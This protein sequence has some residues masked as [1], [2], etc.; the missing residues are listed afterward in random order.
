MS[1]NPPD[2]KTGKIESFNGDVAKV[3]FGAGANDFQYFV[4]QDLKKV[5]TPPKETFRVGDVVVNEGGREGTI[6]AINGNS[7]KVRYG[8]GK[9]NFQME[10]LASLR[11][12]KTAASEAEQEKQRKIFRVEAEKYAPIVRLF[13]Q[14]YNPEFAKVKGGIDAAAIKKA[15]VE[16]AELDALCKSK[17]PGITNSPDVNYRDDVNWRF[18]DWCGMAAKRDELLQSVTSGT[19]SAV[20]QRFIA[21]WKRS[22]DKSLKDP[23]DFVWDDVQ[24][25][26]FDQAAWK[27]KDLPFLQRDYAENG[28]TVP[29]D[30]FDS[31]NAELA[32]LREKIE[33]DSK[34][35]VWEVPPYKDAAV[36]A[37][38]KSKHAARFKGIINVKS[39]LDFTT[40]K[41]F[42]NNLGIPTS[43]I[44][45][46][47]LLVKLPNQNGMCQAR[48]F[49]VE[50]EYTGG[51]TFSAMKIAGFSQA[52]KYMK[53]Q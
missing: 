1:C 33:N 41:L 39:G 9:Y 4:V 52:G 22:I 47:W 46:G 13:E 16:L 36:E 18:A 23:N 14:F 19:Q 7:A 29:A 35:K 30:I 27:A 26:L 43:Q 5:Q 2:G 12:P 28:G 40:W 38:V 3:R 53:C 50:K 20:G 49:A 45:Q 21:G 34:T 32:K 11:N 6:E 15:T 44:K 31:V 37:F 25:M 48:E 17:Y 51:G 24:T 42:K 10:L 8:N